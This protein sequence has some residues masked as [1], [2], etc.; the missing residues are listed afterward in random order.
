[1]GIEQPKFDPTDQ[2]YKKVA[3]LPKEEQANFVDVGDGFIR[4]DVAKYEEDAKQQADR[5][6]KHRFIIDKLFKEDLKVDDVIKEDAEALDRQELSL[7]EK[8][9]YRKYERE[10]WAEFEIASE[11]MVNA[12]IDLEQ[13]IRIMVRK[14]EENS[15]YYDLKELT[16]KGII[17][18]E[19]L[20]DLFEVELARGGL[21]FKKPKAEW[22][23][24]LGEIIGKKINT[25]YHF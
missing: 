10:R 17:K 5:I 9:R 4:K 12:K 8:E 13:D 25:T 11:I 22:H 19:Q 20:I 15:F 18:S 14:D 21:K 3:D 24:K 1:M 6:N 23:K 7:E 16:E 2:K